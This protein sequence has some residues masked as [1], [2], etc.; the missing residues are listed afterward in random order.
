M[1]NEIQFSML[2]SMTHGEENCKLTPDRRQSK[3]LILSTIVDPKK[4]E[5]EILIVI[6]RQF[7]DKWQSKTLFLAILSVFL[8]FVIHVRR[9]IRAFSIV[10]YRAWN[11]VRLTNP[12]T[13]GQ[14]W[15]LHHLESWTCNPLLL[16]VNAATSLAPGCW[17]F[18]SFLFRIHSSSPKEH[19]SLEYQT[20]ETR[21][22]PA[23]LCPCSW[24]HWSCCLR[25]HCRSC[26]SLSI[27]SW[28]EH[29]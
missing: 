19:G 26:Q 7:G 24:T 16:E 13:Q 22:Q 20:A 12:F 28:G 11:L 25:L 5:T 15:F 10:A 29:L 2:K 4:L 3:T 18:A 21:C 23:P 9:L 17:R 8:A 1:W 6:C 14:Q 27:L